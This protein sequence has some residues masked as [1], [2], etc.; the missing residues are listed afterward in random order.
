MPAS[1]QA[2]SIGC[3]KA[4]V[5]SLLAMLLIDK[6]DRIDQHTAFCTDQ[7]MLNDSAS[8]RSE[9]LSYAGMRLEEDFMTRMWMACA[10]LSRTQEKKSSS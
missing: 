10:P 3:A 4:I 8:R 9:R 1:G 2:A 7:Y 6:R 5:R